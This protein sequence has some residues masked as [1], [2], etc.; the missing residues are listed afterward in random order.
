[1][2]GVLEL[3]DA[4]AG[5]TGKVAS[6]PLW[7]LS[8]SDVVGSLQAVHRWE[9]L[10]ALFKVRLVREADGRGIP[11]GEGHRSLP[12]WLR[13]RLLLDPSPARELSHL[14]VALGRRPAVEQ[15]LIDGLL[16]MRQAA[17]IAAAV[18]A[19]PAT[20]GTDDEPDLHAAPTDPDVSPADSDLSSSE[21]DRSQA[22][23]A[24]DTTNAG[25]PDCGRVV[26]EAEAVLLGMAGQLPAY[27]L[28]QV[29]ARILAHVA[30]ELADRA[31]EAALRRQE[32]RAHA[33]RSFTLGLPLDGMV[34]VTGHLDVEAAA[35]VDAALQPLCVP[36]PGDERTPGQKRADALI[37][38]C[39]LALRTA[40]LP[41]HG[42]EPPQVVVTVRY[43][44]LTGQLGGAVLDNGQRLSA[45]TA[46]RM[47]C[48]AKVLPFVL[49]GAGQILD[50]GRS[51]RRAS[52][53]L[54]RALVVRDRGCAFPGCDRP[55]RWC[56][57]HHRRPWSHGGA[58]CLD[59][60]VL[61]CRRHHRVMHDPTQGWRMRL[62][63]DGLPQFIP[64]PRVDLLQRPQHNLYHPRT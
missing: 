23:P 57:S 61:L 20:L 18:D 7:S 48:D 9:Q 14:A 17:V 41:E 62:G 11:A 56:D 27:Q 6:A 35:I 13:S 54:R 64:P 46:R 2:V 8:D 33:K 26:E 45:A 19:I 22:G 50:A 4:L 30:P 29:G 38:V 3:V 47:A 59:N 55:P 21:P 28:R 15:A 16:D 5:E 53:S 1:M 43:D 31:D 24:G 40:Q 42:G 58:T 36:T 63:D 37:D 25:V 44:P 52:G 60:L 12:G 49:G 34:R 10:L 51:R 32:K 39:R